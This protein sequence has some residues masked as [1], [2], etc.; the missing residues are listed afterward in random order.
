MYVV[1]L[2]GCIYF[3]VCTLYFVPEYDQSIYGSLYIWIPIV[4]LLVVVHID[5]YLFIFAILDFGI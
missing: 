2:C 5:L 4:E 1:I 3:Y